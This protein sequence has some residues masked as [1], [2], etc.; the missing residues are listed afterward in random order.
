[1]DYYTL[2]PISFALRVIEVFAQ[3]SLILIILGRSIFGKRHFIG[4]IL[5]SI[6]FEIGKKI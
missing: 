1:M 2:T 6:I 3:F 4:A 5:F